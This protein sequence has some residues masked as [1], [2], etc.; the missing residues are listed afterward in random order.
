LVVGLSFKGCRA[1]RRGKEKEKGRE[2]IFESW[3]IG[4][5]SRREKEKRKIDGERGKERERERERERE[6]E[7]SR[8]KRE[9]DS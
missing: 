2:A 7:R 6:G 4:V 8:K 9:E 3:K 5:L 1:R